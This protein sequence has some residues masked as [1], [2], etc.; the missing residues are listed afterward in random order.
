M[1]VSCETDGRNEKCTQYFGQKTRRKRPLERPRRRWKDYI[2]M[3]LT[4]IGW[5]G[6][7]WMRLAQDRDL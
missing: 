4:E 6:V 7:D 3:N 2:R 1:S 5:E